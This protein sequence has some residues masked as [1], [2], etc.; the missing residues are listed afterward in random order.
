[1]ACRIRRTRHLLRGDRGLHYLLIFNVIIGDGLPAGL[2][3]DE[4]H[5]PIRVEV[6]VGDTSGV[7][8]EALALGMSR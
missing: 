3:G 1:M 2:V 8:A 6:F 4:V 5:H 7:A